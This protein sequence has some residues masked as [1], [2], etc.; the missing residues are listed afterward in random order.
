MDGGL[1]ERARQGRKFGPAAEDYE[2]GRA[3][4]PDAAVE[5]AAAALELGSDATV[6]DLGAGTGKLTRLL[7][8]RFRRVVAVE[9]LP[10]M[11]AVLTANLPH[12]EVVDGTAER[13]PLPAGAV[14]AIFAGDA[15]HWFDGRAALA[16]FARV[17]APGGGVA[18]LW[19]R[20]DGPTEPSLPEPARA[21]AR[22]A[23]ARG[24]V[25]G[26]PRVD[27]GEWREPF[28]KSPF[29][30]L[31]CLEIRHEYGTDRDGLIAGLMSVSSIA[32]LP[33]DDRAALRSELTR[34][35][36][37]GS[38]RQRLLTALYWTRLLPPVWCDRCGRPLAD[39]GHEACAT[40][41]NLEPP[42]FCSRCRRRMKVQVLP[43][44]WTATC[45]VHGD[46]VA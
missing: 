21:L 9:P 26:G 17:L 23:I 46:L 34:L 28:A 45:S 10:E 20:P 16:E 5:R 19:K 24:G 11:R 1:S 18:L 33:A 41:R 42:R 27:R 6:V 43:A 29:G 13:I 7:A 3:P 30:E 25:P 2:R 35:I 39:G 22:A 12:V 37:A 44:G 32:G 15:F 31:N 38:Y 8:G 14:D 4:W 40:A 36:P